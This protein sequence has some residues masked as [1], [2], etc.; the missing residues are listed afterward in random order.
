[1]A[2]LQPGQRLGPYQLGERISRGG[3]GEVWR[4]TKTGEAGWEKAVALKL[5]LPTLDEDRFAQMF[6]T[7][8][9]IAASLDH[10]NIVPVFGFGREGE[11]LY[12][13]MEQVVGRDLR[14]LLERA[15][16]QIM[17]VP[18]SLFIVAEALKGLAYAHERGVI[19][20]DIKPHNTLCSF[21]GSVKL[22]DFGIAK[23]SAES[24]AASRSE[25]KGTAGYIAPEV[26]DGAPASVRSDLF[27]IGLVLWEC[28]TGKK[29]FDGGSEAERLR[30]T[31]ECQVPRLASLG[32][33]VAPGVE[34]LCIR[35][36]ARE[37]TAR[38]GSAGEALHAVLNAPGG[39]AAGSVEMKQAMQWLFGPEI[40]VASA[41]ASAA[42]SALPPAHS[43]PA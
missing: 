12:I 22:T 28:L 33:E 23:L 31:F 29:L 24:G 39:R 34:E 30:R 18:L 15:E 21:E 5:I 4:A 7:E 38:Y 25:V 43:M 32:I 35:L 10:P 26:L 11:L 9:R 20:R 37:P 27:A 16:G 14:H 3:M 42:A 8:A 13:E 2:V 40:A 36:L 17:Q 6:M 1:M 19:H 41:S